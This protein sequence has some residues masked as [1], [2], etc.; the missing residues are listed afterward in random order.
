MNFT[1][2]SSS[3]KYSRHARN[4]EHDLHARGRESPQQ[5]GKPDR[6]G[7]G[8]N[9]EPRPAS[10]FH[11]HRGRWRIGYA[12]R[13]HRD[14]HQCAAVRFFAADFARRASQ[15]H[16]DDGDTSCSSQNA[17]AL[18]P[19]LS[20]RPTKRSRSV[21]RR[22]DCRGYSN[23]PGTQSSSW[24]RCLVQLPACTSVLAAEG[25]ASPRSGSPCS[26]HR[27]S[28]LAVS[29]SSSKPDRTNMRRWLY[30]PQPAMSAEDR[31]AITRT[32]H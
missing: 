28:A 26:S 20:Y 2:G 6:V 12:E 22:R 7:T 5:R 15:R 25:K 19:L 31:L 27:Q 30:T 21:N 8:G 24:C 4:A 10:Q 18:R 11:P 16:S 1:G 23:G 9:L 32:T 14:L 3:Q 13:Q 17:L 29:G